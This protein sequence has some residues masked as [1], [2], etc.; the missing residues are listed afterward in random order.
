M[1]LNLLELQ[2]IPLLPFLH[3]HT[4][5]QKLVWSTSNQIYDPIEPKPLL[6]NT[7]NHQLNNI[8]LF[9]ILPTIAVVFDSIH[10]AL[11]TFARSPPG[12]TVGD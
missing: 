7:K 11:R 9:N 5:E 2:E 12:T 10:K 4:N 6:N 3:Q 8:P 1:L